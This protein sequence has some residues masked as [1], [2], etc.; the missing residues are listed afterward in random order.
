MDP[1]E[2][3][4]AAMADGRAVIVVDDE[5]R[6][7]EGDLIFAAEKATDLVRK[8]GVRGTKPEVR[9]Q[10]QSEGRL[11]TPLESLPL[12]REAAAEGQG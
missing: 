5:G 1:I 9:V 8:H 11:P 12:R 2:T 4:I 3:A 6:E 10:E 7:N